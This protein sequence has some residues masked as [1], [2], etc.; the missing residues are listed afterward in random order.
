MVHWFILTTVFF[1][2]TVSALGELLVFT[3]DQNKLRKCIEFN[4]SIDDDSFN[5]D[6]EITRNTAKF[7]AKRFCDKTL[8]KSYLSR[9][10]S[11]LIHY[12]REKKSHLFKNNQT[13]GSRAIYEALIYCA[14]QSNLKPGDI[15]F[16]KESPDLG[17]VLDYILVDWPVSLPDMIET[18]KGRM[19]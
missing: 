17:K 7:A 3:G 5:K 14:D 15:T 4:L 8:K 6:A 13:Y 19:I 2:T 12:L 18:R 10:I 11:Y 9:H 16:E 1:V